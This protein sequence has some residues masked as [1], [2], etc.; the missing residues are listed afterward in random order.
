MLPTFLWILVQAGPY[1]VEGRDVTKYKPEQLWEVSDEF[2]HQ[3]NYP[4]VV[5]I[6]D[7]VV[8]LDAHDVEAYNVAAWLIWSMGDESRARSYLQRSVKANPSD[9]EPYWELGFHLY[10]RCGEVSASVPLFEDALKYPPFPDRIVRTLAHAYVSDERPGEAVSLWR[11]LDR[12]HRAP[13]A[14][15]DINLPHALQSALQTDL[16]ARSGGVLEGPANAA[17]APRVVTDERHDTDGD[18]LADERTLDLAPPGAAPLQAAWRILYR[19]QRDGAKRVVWHWTAILTDTNQNGSFDDETPLRDEDEDGFVESLPGVDELRRQREAPLGPV[20]RRFVT[21]DR[22]ELGVGPDGRPA[23]FAVE[24]HD[25]ELQARPTFLVATQLSG[26]GLR[27]GAR[28]IIDEDDRWLASGAIPSGTYAADAVP[29]SPAPL[30]AAGGA[31]LPDGRFWL[32]TALTVQGAPVDIKM[33]RDQVLVVKD[34]KLS[35]EPPT[36]TDLHP[37]APAPP[38]MP[39]G[40]RPIPNPAGV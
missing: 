23:P 22:F 40:P 29:G 1:V 31:N 15:I 28:G 2:W 25:G 37:P 36:D 5:K 3:G 26:V 17:E 30:L 7:R 38:N 24:L 32:V 12:E 6:L 20:E 8:E 35:L 4:A 10:D 34:H 14:I 11:K 27:L 33:P 19:G 9:W 13:Q 16:F 39:G 21:P 18:G